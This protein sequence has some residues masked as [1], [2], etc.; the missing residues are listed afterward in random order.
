M[1]TIDDHM[2]IRPALDDA[3]AR[4]VAIGG[5]ATIALIHVLQLPDAFGEI[6]YLGAL[7]VAAAAACL[8]LAALMTRTSDDLAWVAAG[9]LA[10]MIL[11]GYVVSRSVGLPGFTG[12]VGEW[13]E[14]PGLASIVVEC[15]LVAVS[16]AVYLSRH[17][18]GRAAA[19]PAEASTSGA[20]MRPGPSVG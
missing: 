1:Q 6:G 18:L 3:L 4:A 9:G 5:L 8:A 19:A 10:G 14:A 20:A 17:P 11:L 12:D 15:L 16:G 7:F 2:G 13:S